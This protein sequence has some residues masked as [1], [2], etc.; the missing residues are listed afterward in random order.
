MARV[1]YPMLT[2][3]TTL[4]A[5]PVTGGTKG[6]PFSSTAQ[7]TLVLISPVVISVI[8][9]PVLLNVKGKPGNKQFLL[10]DY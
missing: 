3:S 9:S 6:M 4:R 5:V 2:Y 8:I 7:A 1:K 10:I